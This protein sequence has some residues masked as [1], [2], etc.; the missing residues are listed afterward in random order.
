MHGGRQRMVCC[1]LARVRLWWAERAIR[2]P[3][4]TRASARLD[5]AIV[6]AERGC[7]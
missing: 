6:D 4:T 7:K 1:F 3:F 2:W 5:R